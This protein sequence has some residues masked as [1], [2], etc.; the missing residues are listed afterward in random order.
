MQKDAQATPNVVTSMLSVANKKAYVL[1]NSGATHSFVSTVFGMHLD[2]PCNALSQPLLVSTPVG[3]VVLVEEVY[4]DCVLK[5]E[6]K[7]LILDLIPL[8]IHDFDLILGMNWLSSYHASI[9]CFKKEVIFRM[10]I[11]TEFKFYGERDIVPTCL[12]SAMKVKK[13]L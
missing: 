12:I 5:I 4:K 3:D 8:T 13:L 6:D 1:I 11:E 10:P 2:R 7:E 9:D